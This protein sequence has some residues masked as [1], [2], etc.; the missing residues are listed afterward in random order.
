MKKKSFGKIEFPSADLA[1]ADGLLA[2]GGNLEPETLVEAYSSGI[3]PWTVKP[4]TWWSPDPRAIFEIDKFRLTRKMERLYRSGR[5]KFSI[6]E[7]FSGVIRGCAAPGPGRSETWISKEFIAAYE[8]LNKLGIAHSAEVW[9]NDELAGG[10]YGVALGGFFAGESMFYR[11]S[12][13][14]NLC[15]RFFME[16]LHSQGYVLFD[17]QVSTPHTERLGVIEISRAEYLTRLKKALEKKCNIE[18]VKKN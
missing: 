16:Y 1:D 13:A 14:S 9:L 3:Y 7:D 4:I 8:K 5:F 6:D 15:L 11:V 12:N 18:K 2:W 10:L 17:S